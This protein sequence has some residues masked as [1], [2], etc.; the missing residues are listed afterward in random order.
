MWQKRKTWKLYRQ[1]HKWLAPKSLGIW[2][3]WRILS[4]N[5]YYL[6]M[7][8]MLGLTYQGEIKLFSKGVPPSTQHWYHDT[9]TKLGTRNDREYKACLLFSNYSGSTTFPSRKC[10]TVCRTQ[11]LNSRVS[12][13]EEF[14]NPLLI[15]TNPNKMKE[16]TLF[17]PGELLYVWIC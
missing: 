10:S 15:N 5:K 3:L 7:S 11:S 14:S 8:I 1:K 17:L 4:Q 9:I 16:K 13:A 6:P 12:A 2:C